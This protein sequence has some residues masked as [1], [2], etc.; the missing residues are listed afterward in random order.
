MKTLNEDNQR[1]SDFR[2]FHY[3]Q[4]SYLYEIL[5]SNKII[6]STSHSDFELKL[7]KNYPYFLSTAN[8]KNPFIIG[9]FKSYNS[10]VK[11][12]LDYE[13]IRSKYKVIS[14]RYFTDSEEYEQRILSLKPHLLDINNYIKSI[15]IFA[16]LKNLYK[17]IQ[18][19]IV[20]CFSFL[21]HSHEPFHQFS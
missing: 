18:N 10:I 15:S 11:I 9:M 4:I 3:T 19:N 2:I 14:A 17:L 16:A 21:L 1:L 12:E 13:K 20:F 7:S 8:T 6:L 5:Y